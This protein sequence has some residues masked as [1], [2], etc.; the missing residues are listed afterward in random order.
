DQGGS[1][2]P[3]VA[4]GEEGRGQR[5]QPPRDAPGAPPRPRPTSARRPPAARPAPLK[6]NCTPRRA[7]S[8]R[9]AAKLNFVFGKQTFATFATFA[10]CIC[11]S[12]LACHS[13]EREKAMR[14]LTS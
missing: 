5:A 10:V 14:D 9:R 12:L 1:R 8:T 4:G 11:S 3:Q 2:I 6:S 13:Q 7:R